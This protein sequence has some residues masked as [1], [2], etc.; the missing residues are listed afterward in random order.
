[1]FSRCTVFPIA[2]ALLAASLATAQ[3]AMPSPQRSSPLPAYDE[4]W[5]FLSDPDCHADPWDIVKYVQLADRMFVSF[6]GEARES[7]ERF[8]NQDFGLACRVR[9][10]TSCSDTCCMRTFT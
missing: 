5:Q 6:G 4:N 8:G 7:Y 9:T 1:M 2:S 3:T 10:D